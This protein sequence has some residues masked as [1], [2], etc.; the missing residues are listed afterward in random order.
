MFAALLVGLV[1]LSFA[2]GPAVPVR[3]DADERSPAI[4]AFRARRRV[5]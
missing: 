1:L 2:T 3:V 5:S 4:Q